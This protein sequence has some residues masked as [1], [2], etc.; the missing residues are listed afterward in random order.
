[1]LKGTLRL[2]NNAITGIHGPIPQLGESG[3]ASQQ[4]ADP[5]CTAH[6]RALL[7]AEL[8]QLGY[9]DLEFSALAPV[10]S[11]TNLR[12]FLFFSRHKDARGILTLFALL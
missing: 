8:L 2:L 6:C 5:L 9:N 1:V 3:C 7:S 10:F 12:E 11:M 4:K